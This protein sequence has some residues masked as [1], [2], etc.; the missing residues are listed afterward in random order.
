MKKYFLKAPYFIKF[1]IVNSYGFLLS[2]KRYNKQFYQYLEEYKRNDKNEVFSFDFKT[3]RKQIENN[4]FYNVEYKNIEEY[5]I[6]N[7]QI[8][9]EHYS[10]IINKREVY[11][12]LHTSGTTGS[13]LKFPVSK[14]FINHQW[15]IFWK[16]RNIHG[17]ILDTWCAN[18][19]SQTMFEAEQTIPP[20][21]FKSYPTRQLLLSLYHLRN[22]T[23]KVYMDVIKVNKTIWLHAF[24]SV[25]NHFANLIRDNNL[26]VEAKQ[27]N[28]KI[29][30]TSSEKLFDHQKENIENIFGCDVRQL[31][32]LTEGVVNI[33]ECENG[34]LHVDE[35]YSYVE[36]L[37]V[38]GSVNEYKII[39]TSYHNSAF[40]L[41][42][43]DTGDT[44]ILHPNG[45]RCKC[46]RKSRVVK[47]ILGR[48][49][50]YLTLSNGSKIGRVSSIFKSLL[51]VKEAQIVQNKA[52]SAEF[53]VVKDNTYTLKDEE[54]LKE[55]IQEK[56]GKDF[57]F[58]IIYLDSIERTKSGKLKFVINKIDE[59]TNA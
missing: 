44:C 48:D 21:W 58:K 56:L 5:P 13:G 49:D 4:K 15:A 55:Q 50:D 19:I 45:F 46:G 8:I 2:K 1:F 11:D 53:R 27:M 30:T 41:V 54:K 20:Y 12:Y 35:S 28:L 9:K 40:P 24:P 43:Y 38:D 36:F 26:L 34:T 18:I 57:I 52:G 14:K 22:D 16:F 31:Y 32:G 51:S 33:F 25:L 59:N 23:V 37:S 10:E 47:E 29:I 17:I 6:I 3:F 7:K 39:G 42:R